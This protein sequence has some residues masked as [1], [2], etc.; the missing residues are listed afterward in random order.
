[1]LVVDSS[2]KCPSEWHKVFS[3]LLL[4]TLSAKRS[5][6]HHNL[7]TSDAFTIVIGGF[8]GTPVTAADD[9]TNLIG[10]KIGQYESISLLTNGAI[11]KG[12]S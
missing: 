2:H 1:L 6:K 12:S 8:C 4:V 5:D 3:N 11:R 10:Q 9:M 7:F